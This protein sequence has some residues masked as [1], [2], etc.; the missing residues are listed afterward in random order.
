MKILIIGSRSVTNFDLSPY[1]PK[2]TDMIISG[3]AKGIDTIAEEYADKHKISKLIIR[4]RYDLYGR[5]APIKRNEEMIDMADEIIVIWDGTSKGTKYSIDYAAKK[6][7][8]M[9]LIMTQ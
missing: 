5:A 3:G 9:N 1:V 2:E 6:G 7:K 4:P 8:K